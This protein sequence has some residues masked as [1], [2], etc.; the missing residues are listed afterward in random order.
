MSEVPVELEGL[1]VAE[2][3]SSQAFGWFMRNVNSLH[4]G[5]ASRALARTPI[6][7]REYLVGRAQGV[8]DV[9][10]FMLAAIS[11]NGGSDE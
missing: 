9:R 3:R 4:A 2:L 10:Q 6:E 11:R 7:H 8:D 1:Y 5:A